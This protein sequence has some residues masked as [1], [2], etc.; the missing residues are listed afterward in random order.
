MIGE[1]VVFAGNA[2]RE[3]AEKICERLGQPMAP[4]LI[5]AFS[6]GETR[7]ELKQNVRGRDV[8]LIQPTC[9]PANDSLMELLIML[10]AAEGTGRVIGGQGEE[11]FLQ[12]YQLRCSVTCPER[13]DDI[14]LA[15]EMPVQRAAGDPGLLRDLVQGR[16]TDPLH[17][18]QPGGCLQQSVVGS[19]RFFLRFPGHVSVRRFL[20]IVW[21]YLQE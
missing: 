21:S 13:A 3:I 8:F 4:A 11:P 14:V 5:G 15:L 9:S 20:V 16:D 7:V 12:R 18:E 10:D 17:A 1:L 19:L 6:D 2:N